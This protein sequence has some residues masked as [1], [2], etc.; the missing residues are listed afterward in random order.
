MLLDGLIA[1][2]VPDVL[3]P[4]SV[5]V[6][7]AGIDPAELAPVTVAGGHLLCVAAV[8]PAKGHDVLLCPRHVDGPSV[9][10]CLRWQP[11]P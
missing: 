9:K 11:E 1:S 2:T 3:V 7:E 4:Q 6:A 8:T 10:L 5:N